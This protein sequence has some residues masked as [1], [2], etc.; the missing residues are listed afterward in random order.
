MRQ[1]S[2]AQCVV[3][4]SIFAALMILAVRVQSRDSG[5]IMGDDNL[6]PEA[7]AALVDAE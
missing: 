1:E 4:L 3:I 6:Q 2:I 5:S 7:I